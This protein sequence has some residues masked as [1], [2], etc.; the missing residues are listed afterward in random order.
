MPIIPIVIGVGLGFLA[1]RAVKNQRPL[2]DAH[3]PKDAE[4]AVV[5]A[6]SHETDP[7]KL[8]AFGHALLQDFP[9]AASVLFARAVK[10]TPQAGPATAAGGTIPGTLF[11]YGVNGMTDGDLYTYGAT[12]GTLYATAG[13]SDVVGWNL[14]HAIKTMAQ[15]AAKI[16]PL[17]FIPG[18]GAA[19]VLATGLAA[20]GHTK[21]GKKIGADLGKNKV[22]N[23][24]AH[25]Y[26]SGYMQANPAFFAKSLVLSATDDVLHG[27]RLDKA[28]LDQRHAVA[29][30][31]TDKAKYASQ[32]TGVPPQVTP[33]LTAAAN[34][35][36]G[37]PVPAN[38]IA[39][40]SSV[41]GAAVGPAASDAL[42]QGAQYGDQLT[43]GATSQALAAVSRARQSLPQGVQHAFDSGLALKV[44]QDLQQKGYAAAHGLLRDMHPAA[45]VV[46]ALNVATN[47]L[48]GDALARVQAQLPP[49]AAA[50]AHQAASA[51]I[52]NPGMARLSS[53][54]LAAQLGIPEIIARVVLAS[55]SHEVPGAPLLH[56]H[57]LEAVVGR[58]APPTGRA[59]PAAPFVAH[60]NQQASSEAA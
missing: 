19:V 37:K 60:Y 42:E 24:I 28:I 40:A 38:A 57:R 54:E 58:P 48:L 50:I 33:A 46:G 25:A 31:L 44:G 21:A 17:A 49:N 55:M 53:N 10:V 43:N 47:D 39:A 51:V 15:D 32:A 45:K 6:A 1:W 29:G 8:R 7:S 27:K 14:F 16:G 56:P 41:V 5:F 34:V 59:R 4:N 26:T 36:E 35:A 23:G 3:L 18:A 13:E 12:E 20:A 2:L 52:A 22:L 9:A 30:W 11:T